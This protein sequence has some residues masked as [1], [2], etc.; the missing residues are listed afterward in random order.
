MHRLKYL[1]L[2]FSLRALSICA[3]DDGLEIGARKPEPSQA[4]PVKLLPEHF[5]AAIQRILKS[6]APTVENEQKEAVLALVT[7]IRATPELFI[8]LMIPTG[9]PNAIPKADKEVRLRVA[10]LMGLSGDRRLLQT[11]INS[12]V[13]DPDEK[14]RVAAGFAIPRLD[15]PAAIRKLMDLAIAKDARKYPWA[16]RKAAAAALRRYGDLY[17]VDRLMKELGYELAGGNILDVKNRPRGK[18][19]GLATDNPLMLPDSAPANPPP[20]EDMYPV[21]YALKEV[22]RAELKHGENEKDVR[23]WQAW[24]RAAKP[25]FKFAD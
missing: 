5:Q 10:T 8:P 20:P 2:F 1:V 18:Q 21:L 6:P 7:E 15:E 22:T 12:A 17:V 24:W 4:A 3:E 19:V 13:Y 11:L 14:V 23:S 25:A 9:Y 16:H